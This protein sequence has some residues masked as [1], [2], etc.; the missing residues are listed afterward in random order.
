MLNKDYVAMTAGE[1]VIRKMYM[2]GLGRAA[3]IGAEN[4]FDYSLGNPS[5]APPA[6]YTDALVDL[7]RNE[8]PLLVHG[9]SPNV[10]MMAMR[11][12]VADDLNARFGTSYTV[13]NIFPTVSAAGA[14]AHALRAVVTPELKQ[15]VITFAPF[16]PEYRPYVGGAGAELRVISADTTAFQINFEE[17]ERTI[18]EKTAAILVNSP[19]NPSGVVYST[20]TID[21]LA[22]ILTAKSKEFGHVIY[23]ISDE[24]YRE[25]VFEGVDAPFI[26]KHY[27]DTIVCYSYSKSMSIPGARTGYCL[28]NTEAEGYDDFVNVCVQI[29]RGIGHN[30][31]PTLMQLA[32]AKAPGALSDLKVYEENC[33]ILYNELSA[34]GFEIVKPGGT[35]YMFPK[36]PG[37]DAT[38][39]CEKAK[40]F[41][42]IL[43]PSDSFGVPGYFRIAYCVPTEKVKRSLE[44]F[45]KLAALYF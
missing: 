22:Q 40:E 33:N 19:N 11:Q 37:G 26:A 10:G 13:K 2:Y 14:I 7:V 21:R 20:A 1:S 38:A 12:A 17:L 28:I 24:P 39:F 23:L 45:K 29:S 42:L 30:C 9:Y 3:Q 34:M 8:N 35:F 5:V 44:A 32:V 27:K 18:D 43:V 31:P 16:F 36:A 15:N 25:I 6:E 4:V 41:D